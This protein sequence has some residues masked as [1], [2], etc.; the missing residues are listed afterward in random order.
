MCRMVTAERATHGYLKNNAN[1]RI[2]GLMS[3][4]YYAREKHLICGVG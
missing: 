3:V 4:N 1:S 2:E